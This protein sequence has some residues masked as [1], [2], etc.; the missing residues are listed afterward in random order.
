MRTRIK[1]YEEDTDLEEYPTRSQEKR[2]MSQ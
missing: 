2:E 1:E